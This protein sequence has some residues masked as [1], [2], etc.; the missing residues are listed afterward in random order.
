M[1]D[2]YLYFYDVIYKLQ[3]SDKDNYL[4]NNLE[5]NMNEFVLLQL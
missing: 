3:Y 2:V 4:P 5:Q 1:Y